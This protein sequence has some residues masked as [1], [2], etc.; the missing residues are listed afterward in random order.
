[1][2]HAYINHVLWLVMLGY[3]E[4]YVSLVAL[5]TRHTLKLPRSIRMIDTRIYL[6]RCKVCGEYALM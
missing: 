3:G 4:L 1:M 6:F 2:C 5:H